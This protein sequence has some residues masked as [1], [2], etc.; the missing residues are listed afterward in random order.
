MCYCVLVYCCEV[1]GNLVPFYIAYLSPSIAAKLSFIERWVPHV[2]E[3][4]QG[5][6][7]FYINQ[8]I[9]A[10]LWHGTWYLTKISIFLYLKLE[11]YCIMQTLERTRTKLFEV[12]EDCKTDQSWARILEKCD[13]AF[14]IVVRRFEVRE[15]LS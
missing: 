14:L 15:R 4:L 11:C 3:N 6:W 2:H 5:R 7:R 8:Q 10:Y 9:P 12:C 1:Y 13:V